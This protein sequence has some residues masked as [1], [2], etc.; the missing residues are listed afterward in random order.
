MVTPE[1]AV[2]G[3]IWRMIARWQVAEAQW[4]AERMRGYAERWIEEYGPDGEADAL[5]V[6]HGPCEWGIEFPWEVR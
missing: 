4:C 6:R 1:R 5:L 2:L 3:L